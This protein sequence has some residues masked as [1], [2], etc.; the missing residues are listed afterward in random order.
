MLAVVALLAAV[1]HPDADA[2]S[3]IDKDLIRRVVRAHLDEVRACYADGLTRDPTLAGR[4]VIRFTIASSGKVTES[5]VS[6]S[7]LG[8]AAVGQCI[9]D[10]AL[11]WRFV[12]GAQILVSYPFVL[13][14]EAS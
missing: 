6:E 13:K 14:P 12:G 9:A 3:S 7:D 5:Q 4:V 1:S 8:D 2:A 10:A 11:R